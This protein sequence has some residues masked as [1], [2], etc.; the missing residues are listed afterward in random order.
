MD[1]IILL[2]FVLLHAS[3]NGHYEH[4]ST[5]TRNLFSVFFLFKQNNKIRVE[6]IKISSPGLLEKVSV[7]CSRGDLRRFK[8]LLQFTQAASSKYS[9]SDPFC[10]SAPTEDLNLIGFP[11]TERFKGFLCW[12]IDST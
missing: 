12:Y 3:D 6:F 11:K 7:F 1:F 5:A 2:V 9:I 4:I 8:S 10:G